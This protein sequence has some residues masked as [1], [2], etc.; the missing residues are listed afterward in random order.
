MATPQLLGLR[1]RIEELISRFVDFDIPFDRAPNAEEKDKIAAF[2]LLVH[3][4]IE[5]FIESRVSYAVQ[6]SVRLWKRDQKVTRTLLMLLLRW[7]VPGEC[8]LAGGLAQS[9]F[10]SQVDRCARRAEEE[11]ENNNG[12]KGEALNRLACSAG[13]LAED[14]NPTLTGAA[15][16]YGKDRGDVAHNP[17]GTV[18]SLNDPRSEAQAAK[19][20]VDE[21]ERFD[22]RL[23]RHLAHAP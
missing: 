2:K 1:N 13:F 14:L 3:A 21:L 19:S 22:D 8:S 7:G 17:V 16:T 18:R 15:T 5:T 4:E 23:V 9:D 6:E 11:I 10:D 12:I 20:L